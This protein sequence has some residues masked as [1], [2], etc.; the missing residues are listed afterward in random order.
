MTAPKIV[1]YGNTTVTAEQLS[2]LTTFQFDT[3]FVPENCP[4]DKLEFLTPFDLI[5]LNESAETDN[6]LERIRSLRRQFAYIPVLLAVTSPKPSFLVQAFRYG[7]SDCILA[8]FTEEQL[9]NI[10]VS[11]LNPTREQPQGQHLLGIVPAGIQHFD[12]FSSRKEADLTVNFIGTFQLYNKGEQISLPGGTRQRSLLA[13]LLYYAKNQPI[14]RDRII[15]SFWPDHDP[16]C[17]KN[18]LN[19]GICNLRRHLEKYFKQ[20]IICFE[21]GF[22]S[23]NSD[24]VI[25]RDID[26]FNQA[27]QQG[28]TAF[29][30]GQGKNAAHM[31]QK[32]SQMGTELL[33]E[34]LNEDW[35][36]RPR[37]EFTE[38]LFQSLD[39]LSSFQQQNHQQELAL[40]TLRIM[41][42]KDNCLEAA[43]RKMMACFLEL[44]KKEK[45]VRQYQECKRVLAEKLQML[46]SKQTEDL[47]LEAR[48]AHKAT[49]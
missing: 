8:P 12:L 43:H 13:F 20:E 24:M 3:T 44:G 38:K 48:G 6:D 17:A 30:Y 25:S 45:A 27:Y 5:I 36:I 41:L 4:T 46:P 49:A 28:K 22:F 15:K 32:A 37:E 42:Y 19:V 9:G 47:Y 11:N 39:H 14:H 29:R 10:I 35:T 21:N 7:I 16:D 33:E 1:V 31:F 18:N 34:F 23:L 26:V 40:E 2:A